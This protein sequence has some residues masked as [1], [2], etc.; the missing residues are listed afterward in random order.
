MTPFAHL[1][2][3][4]HVQPV[5]AV[6]QP[7][8]RFKVPLARLGVQVGHGGSV[9]VPPSGHFVQG[10]HPQAR[11]LWAVRV[12]LEHGRDRPFHRFGQKVDPTSSERYRHQTVK[13]PE[14]VAHQTRW[15]R[16]G[17]AAVLAFRIRRHHD[18][19]L[20]PYVVWLLSV[21]LY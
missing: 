15:R 4:G 16:D 21:R 17:F 19:G 20:L 3:Q 1:S 7:A 12:Q 14:H 13:R 2:G 5:A 11:W 8:D 18:D 6:V 10:R 9:Y